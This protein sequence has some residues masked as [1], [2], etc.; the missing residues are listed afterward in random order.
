MA[1]STSFA[2]LHGARRVEANWAVGRTRSPWHCR[3]VTRCLEA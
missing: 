2:A 3:S 1:D